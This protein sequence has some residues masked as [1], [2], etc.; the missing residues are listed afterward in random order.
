MDGMLVPPASALFAAEPWIEN[1]FSNVLLVQFN[2]RIVAYALVA[3]AVIHAVQARAA[4]PGSAPARRAT[5]LAG[6]ALA[7]MALGIVTL[8]LAVP[9]WAGLAHQLLA[10]LLL[11]MAGVHARLCG[12]SQRAL[13]A[14]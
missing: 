11:A 8:L 6:M 9:I 2:H 13:A 12:G 14:A 10:M 4:M 7:Q 1:V 3:L 5:A